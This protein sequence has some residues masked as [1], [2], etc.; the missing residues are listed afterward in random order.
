MVLRQGI[1]GRFRFIVTKGDK[2]VSFEQK[3]ARWAEQGIITASQ[4]AQIVAFEK[5]RRSVSPMAMFALF[6]AVAVGLGVVSLIAFN[7]NAIPDGVKIAGLGVLM[8]LCAV[9]CASSFDKR[10]VFFETGLVVGALFSLSGIGLTA[11]IFHLSGAFWQTA[12]FWMA[13]IFPAAFVSRKTFLPTLFVTTGFFAFAA[14]PVGER[15]F[16]F[17]FDT[18][19]FFAPTAFSVASFALWRGVDL[20]REKIVRF[21]PSLS[22]FAF[23]GGVFPLFI[24]F[25]EKLTAFAAA[26]QWLLLAGVACFALKKEKKAAFKAAFA[27]AALRLLEFFV[28]TFKSL[29]ATGVGLICFGAVLWAAVFIARKKGKENAE[30]V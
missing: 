22:F 1:A 21:A 10:P 17:F 20:V 7:W 9:G 12:L 18:D 28:V 24:P 8:T 27:G 11:Q 30:N 5:K 13:L 4:A 3:A 26:F 6:G 16:S 29:L 2:D 25:E 19:S 14:S 15:F 23:S